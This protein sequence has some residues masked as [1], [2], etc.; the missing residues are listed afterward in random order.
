MEEVS[1]SDWE[2]NAV[3]EEK[4]KEA[5]DA[6]VQ[7]TAA[8]I[9]HDSTKRAGMKDWNARVTSAQ[10]PRFPFEKE[11]CVPVTCVS[12]QRVNMQE[13]CKVVERAAS[14]AVSMFNDARTL[15][16]RDTLSNAAGI[17]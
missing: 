16:S 11:V 10:L 4:E 9:M 3:D 7:W 6:N 13:L 15:Q 1:D 5:Q 17:P 2:G 8:P 12:I 14:V